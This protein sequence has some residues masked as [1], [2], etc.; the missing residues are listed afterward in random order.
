MKVNKGKMYVNK[1]NLQRQIKGDYVGKQRDF[2]YVN[3][4][5]FSS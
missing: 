3:K 2:I 4:W 5:E 1:R